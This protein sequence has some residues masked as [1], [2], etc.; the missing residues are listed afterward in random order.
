MQAIFILLE[1]DLQQGNK[2][3]GGLLEQN[4]GTK[5]SE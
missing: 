1:T 4:E 3:Q 5:K 2:S